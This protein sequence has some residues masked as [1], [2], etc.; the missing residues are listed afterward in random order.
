ML[1]FVSILALLCGI[2]VAAE[3]AKDEALVG[4]FFKY[5]AAAKTLTIKVK[6]EASGLLVE[7]AL[8]VSEKTVLSEIDLS[9]LFEG[10][11]LKVSCVKAEDGAL[12]ASKIELVK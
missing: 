4:V 7:K 3:E 8:L 10:T 11:A 2:A 5:D 9:K 6:D 12:K 1:R